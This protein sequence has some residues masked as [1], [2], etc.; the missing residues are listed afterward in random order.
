MLDITFLGSF[1]NLTVPSSDSFFQSSVLIQIFQQM[2]LQRFLLIF[3]QYLPLKVELLLQK[4]L[5][6]RLNV[7]NCES[8]NLTEWGKTYLL[9]PDV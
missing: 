8:T 1:F 5:L 4:L 9:L 3:Y 6:R 2:S 7:R